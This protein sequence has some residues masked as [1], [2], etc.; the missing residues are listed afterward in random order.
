MKVKRHR[1]TVVEVFM[2]VITSVD[3]DCGTPG[4]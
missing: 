1:D 3:Q 4:L 2:G